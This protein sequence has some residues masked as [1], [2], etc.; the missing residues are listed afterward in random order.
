QDRDERA[1]GVPRGRGRDDARARGGRSPGR[2]ATRAP[3]LGLR[4]PGE[5]AHHSW[6]RRT[7]GDHPRRL[8]DEHR[9]LRQHGGC[10][11]SDRARRGRSGRAP[12]S[13]R[14]HRAHGR[15]RGPHLGSGNPALE[16]MRRVVV[17]GLGM[18]TPLGI[19]VPSNWEALR[20]GR[21]GIGPITRFDADG[22]PWRIAGEVRGFRAEDWVAPREQ[23]RMDLFILYALA[24]ATEAVRDARLTVDETIAD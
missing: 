3:A 2:R 16:L 6:R 11:D 7:A 24:A 10:L 12:R 5:R 4:A 18:V 13:G 23:G 8:L 21:S 1:R 17:T 14:R 20:A 19:G 9:A 15:G 22:T